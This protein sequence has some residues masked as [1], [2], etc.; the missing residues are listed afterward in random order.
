MDGH[1]VPNITIGPVVVKSLRP[2]S[3]LLFDVHLMITAPENYW[4]AFA[5]AGADLINFHCEVKADKNKL[6][7][8]IKGSKKLAGMS[9]RPRTGLSEIVPYLPSLD[10]V[11]VMSVEP[12]FAGQAFKPEMLGASAMF[13]PFS[14]KK[15][16]NVSCRLTAE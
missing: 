12:G 14:I 15:T 5:G 8:A 10:L 2:R 7:R 11:L 13:A 16:R 9:I 3:K 6:I 4:E 1:F